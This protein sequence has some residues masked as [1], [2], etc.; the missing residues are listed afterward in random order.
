MSLY[1][2]SELAVLVSP[3]LLWL[4]ISEFWFGL[5]VL[6]MSHALVKPKFKFAADIRT[7]LT[8]WGNCTFPEAFELNLKFWLEQAGNYV[9]VV[10]Y[11]Q[12]RKS[13]MMFEYL[14]LSDCLFKKIAPNY[15][16]EV[17]AR[18]KLSE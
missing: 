16:S 14:F 10:I 18:T 2:I 11:L 8:P 15:L 12:K 17:I 4:L 7:I 9:S 5:C 13:H 3:W 6:V 1:Q